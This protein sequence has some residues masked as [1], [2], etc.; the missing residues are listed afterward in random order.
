MRE[1]KNNPP[2]RN[3]DD[4]LSVLVALGVP[5]MATL[6]N[7]RVTLGFTVVLLVTL[8]VQYWRRS[9]FQLAWI[10]SLAGAAAA[11]AALLVFPLRPKH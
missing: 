7:P 8:T 5:L 10:I 6:A 11:L 4:W 9:P 3:E 1:A 2:S